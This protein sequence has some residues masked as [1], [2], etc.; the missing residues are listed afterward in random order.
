MRIFFD[1]SPFLSYTSSLNILPLLQKGGLAICLLAITCIQIEVNAEN[2][3]LGNTGKTTQQGI[4]KSTVSEWKNPRLIHTLDILTDAEKGEDKYRNL[5]REHGSPYPVVI[6][7]DGKKLASGGVNTIRLWDVQT[8]K[9]IEQPLFSAQGVKP[10]GITSIF[11]SSDGKLLTIFSSGREIV[12]FSNTQ[13]IRNNLNNSNQIN[14]SISGIGGIDNWFRQDQ[15]GANTRF[16]FK[17]SSSRTRDFTKPLEE[18]WDIS[19]RTRVSSRDA[20]GDN[21]MLSMQFYSESET[22]KPVSGILPEESKQMIKSQHDGEIYSLVFSADGKTLI[23][24]GKD[25]RIRIWSNN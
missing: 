20:N 9:E 17:I 5:P 14:N 22:D 11:F 8:G 19:T 25:G 10:L 12:E 13:S 3:N 18:I 15:G 23:T 16:E 24:S 6:S 4:K 1:R 7:P 21:R 2:V